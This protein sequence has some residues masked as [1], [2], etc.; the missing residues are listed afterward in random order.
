VQFVLELVNSK[1]CKRE[2]GCI[3]GTVLAPGD[4]PECTRALLQEL[5]SIL[6]RTSLLHVSS[7]LVFGT[8][9][10]ELTA[11]EFSSVTVC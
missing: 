2:W 11:T 3:E 8:I 4:S 7:F 1:L 6:S 5:W 9:C 10:L